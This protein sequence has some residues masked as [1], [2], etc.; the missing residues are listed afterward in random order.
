VVAVSA[1]WLAPGLASAQPAPRVVVEVMVSHTSNRAGPI[2]ARA[3]ELHRKLQKDFRYESLRVL[4]TQRLALDLDEVGTLTLPSGRRFRVQ[5][6]QVG[7][8]GVLLAVDVEGTLKTDLR[9]RNGHLVV[10][11]AERYEDGRIVIS[12]EPH[13]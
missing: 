6:L 3:S 1:L 2:D 13:F 9:V 11:G 5:P 4:Q 8:R 12:L 7:D 10:L